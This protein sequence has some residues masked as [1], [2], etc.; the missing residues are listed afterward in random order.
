MGD[1]AMV[2]MNERVYYIS[3]VYGTSPDGYELIGRGNVGLTVRVYGQHALG[4]Q[5]TS[6]TRD[7]HE[8]GAADR[9][10]TEEIVSVVY[11]LLGDDNFGA[12]EW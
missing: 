7:S 12:V 3:D 8:A 6:S 10:Q 1:R 4:L 5:F 9:H 2:D 11:T